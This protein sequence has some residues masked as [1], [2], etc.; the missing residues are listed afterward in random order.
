MS[1][2]VQFVQR[3]I[4]NRPAVAFVANGQNELYYCR[5]LDE[6]ATEW[7]QPLLVDDGISKSHNCGI[8]VVNGMPALA[9]LD[10]ERNYIVCSFASDA[11]GQSWQ[12]P[13]YVAATGQTFGIGLDFIV[14]IGGR[15]LI[16]HHRRAQGSDYELVLSAPA[17]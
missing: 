12:P 5:S 8:A 6:A 16:F 13:M 7:P 14:G 1:D 10:S 11:E 9:Y 17:P 4:G 15:P 2:M 3:T